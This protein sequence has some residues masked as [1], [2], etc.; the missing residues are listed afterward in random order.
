MPALLLAQGDPQAKNLLRQAI[1]ARYGIT[2]PV[3]ESLQIEFKGRVRT[4]L[5]FVSTWVPVDATAYFRFPNH[6]RWDFTARPLGV[7]VRRGVEAFD[8]STYRSGRG[9]APTVEMDEQKTSST[10]RQL[11]AIAGLLLTPLGEH[12]VKLTSGNENCFEATNTQLNDA[13]S[14]YLR[15]SKTIDYLQV[16]CWNPETNRE[17]AFYLRLSEEQKP[18]NGFMLPTKISAFWGD[19]AFYEVEPA[20]VENNPEISD[21]VFDLSEEGK[22]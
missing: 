7:P 22:S 21:T 2:P 14:V 1:E 11:W 9:G 8:G 17:E 4:K 5:G 19:N 6:M 12:F 13:V 16:T 18:V 3:I 15:P 10:R 20:K